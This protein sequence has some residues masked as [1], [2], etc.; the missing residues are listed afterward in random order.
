[1]VISNAIHRLAGAVGKPAARPCFGAV[2]ALFA[3]VLLLFAPT[4]AN[5]APIVMTDILGRTVTLEKPAERIV[6]GT[7]RSISVLALIH[8]DPVSRIVGWRDDFKR[9]TTSYAAWQKA[10]PA[11]VLRRA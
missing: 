5:A 6:L 9:D 3:W 4:P 2:S 8:P 1:M 10:F 11:I 7:G